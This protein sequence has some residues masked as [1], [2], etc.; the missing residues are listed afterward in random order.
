MFVITL[1]DVIAVALILIVCVAFVVGLLVRVIKNKAKGGR[2]A[3]ISLLACVL[4]ALCGC[5]H[6]DTWEFCVSVPG[7]T[8]I[9][10]LMDMRERLKASGY[11]RFR[12]HTV[13]LGREIIIIHATEKD[14]E[15]CDNQ[16]R[17]VEGRGNSHWAHWR[18]EFHDEDPFGHID[19]DKDTKLIGGVR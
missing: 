2:K 11:K 12:I 8:S 9:D 15:R 16:M 7:D 14:A 6:P 10:R 5:D 18:I 1:E 17:T 4:L 19:F 3:L 13:G